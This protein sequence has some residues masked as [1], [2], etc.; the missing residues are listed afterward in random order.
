MKYVPR[1]VL[2]A[3]VAGRE[4]SCSSLALDMGDVSVTFLSEDLTAQD[5]VFFRTDLVT[6]DDFRAWL[7]ETFRPPADPPPVILGK[8]SELVEIQSS[9]RLAAIVQIAEGRPGKVLYIRTI[10]MFEYKGRRLLA[11]SA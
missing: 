2:E 7:P 11:I 4:P 5:P 3:A 8:Q 1:T 10:T 6:A 9:A